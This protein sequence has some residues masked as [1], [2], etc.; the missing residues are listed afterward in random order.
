[1]GGGGL[2]CRLAKCCCLVFLAGLGVLSAGADPAGI[3]KVIQQYAL[4][5]AN[6][7]PQRDPQDWQLLGSNDGGKTW[8]TLDVRRNEIFQARQQRKLYKIGNTNAYETYQLRIDKVRDPGAVVS[9]QLAELELMGLTEDDLGPTPIFLDDI[10]AQGDN[11]PAETVASLFDGR[12][13]TKWMDWADNNPLTRASWIQ[14]HYLNPA[15]ATVTNLS[16]LLALRTRAGDGI[17][18][19]IQAVVAGRISPGN[20]ICLVDVTGCIGLGGIEGA[21]TL[22]AGQQVLITGVS[23][24]AGNQAGIRAGRAQILGPLANL[25][26][27]HLRPE[28]PLPTGE[29]LKWAEIE[30][31]IQSC[32]S[33]GS[34]VTF[35]VQDELGNMR[36]HLPAQE[37]S[38]PLPRPGT[39]ISVRGICL[40][41]FNERGQWVAANLWAAGPES[42]M[43]PDRQVKNLAPAALPAPTAPAPI[44]ATTLTPIEQIRRLSQA[45]LKAR[46]HVRIRGV[47]TDRLEGFVQDDT[48]GIEVIFPAVEKRKIADLGAYLDID[49]LAGLDDVGNPEISADHI[50]VLGRGTLPQ[51]QKLSLSQLMSGRID[52]Q[53]IEVQGVV[54]STDGSHVLIICYGQE[55]MATLTAAPARLVNELVDA[56]VR[57]RGV[58]VTARDEQGRVQGIHLLIPSLEYVDVITPPADPAILPVRKIGSLLGLSGPLESFHRVKVEGVVTLQQNQKVFLQDGTGSAMLILKADVLLDPRFGHSHWLYWQTPQ[59]GAVFKQREKFRPGERV[60]AVGFTETHRYSPVLTEATLTSLR[61]RE[62]LK[63]VALTASDLEEGGLDSALVTLDG[64]LRSQ[65]TMGANTVL[66]LEWEDNVLQVF[67]P[68]KDIDLSK[69]ALGSRLRV[70]GVCQVDP[71][72]YAELGLGVGAVRILTRSA[73]DLL[74]LERPPWWTV[75][76]ALAF[77]GGMAF[78]ILAALIWIKELRRQ[79]GEQ[80]MQ[81]TKEIQLREQMERHRALEQERARIAKDLHDD[82]GAN[83][84]QIVFLSDR[85]EV[86]RHDGQEVTRWFDLIPAIARRTIQS[87]DEIVWAINPRHDS[88]ESLANY[89]S[90]FAQQHLALARVR[91]VLDVP[92]VLPAMPLT[93]EV[94]HNLLLT[95]REALQN[96]VT[97]AAATEVNLALK[98]DEAGVSITIADNG[99]GFDP[100]AV[101]PDGNGLQNMR[102]RLQGIG[103]RLKINSQPGQGTTVCLFVPKSLLPGRAIG[104]NGISDHEL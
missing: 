76:R 91:C 42:L 46:P 90:Q 49:G 25:M 102:R 17:R 35:D 28:Q 60:Q 32:H 96:A 50:E 21:E 54:R 55:L 34:E 13:E 75:Q 80:T 83:L 39:R 43:V 40:G 20:K 66:A 64:L 11:P 61:A 5:S 104:G 73:E 14:W 29:D 53:W 51:A 2:F 62:S 48:A 95:T 19:R 99:K 77:M 93:A 7:F 72:P 10:S 12:V 15:D 68:G 44:T 84:T 24:W 71:V 101:S 85:V 23:E 69:L 18:V 82:L 98:L 57:V 52:A 100:L 30:G 38:A 41:A 63:S 37:N 27:E 47:I 94:R 103:G 70:T 88:L 87:L 6:D 26:P 81:L 97:H 67:V 4:T 3:K 33:T 65:N 45:Q 31:E 74:V 56:E 86:A 1:M 16:Q 78:V 58:G 79:V 8:T 89:L 9:V 36:V 92:T 59:S 22:D